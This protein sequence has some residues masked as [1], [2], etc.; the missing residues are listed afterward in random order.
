MKY[1]EKYKVRWHDTDAKGRVRPTGI[2]T[3]M[4]ETAN[5]QFVSHGRDLDDERREGEG[6]ADFRL[7]L[8]SI[9]VDM[10]DKHGN[11]RQANARDVFSNIDKA[12]EFFDKLVRNL[13]TPIDLAYILE[14][15]MT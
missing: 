15:E 4:Q 9:R 3:Y 2:L 10:T 1:T 11:R 7:P 5:L 12:A 13:A 6:V 8:Y 14:D